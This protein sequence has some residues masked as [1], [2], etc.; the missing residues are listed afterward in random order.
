VLENAECCGLIEFGPKQGTS[1]RNSSMY[2]TWVYTIQNIHAQEMCLYTERHMQTNNLYK[3]VNYK[4]LVM[5]KPLQEDVQSFAL[6][7]FTL[8]RSVV[9]HKDKLSRS[10]SFLSE[11]APFII[12]EEASEKYR[13][14]QQKYDHFNSLII[15]EYFLF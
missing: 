9:S 2:G 8:V 13:Q 5:Y 1:P 10:F 12:V 3:D 14:F 6:Q 11:E 15:A 4:H 7:L